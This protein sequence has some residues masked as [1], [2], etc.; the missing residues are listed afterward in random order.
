M[1][2]VVE[3]GSLVHRSKRRLQPEFGKLMHKQTAKTL[4]RERSECVS[5][6]AEFPKSGHRFWDK[7][8]LKQRNLS[9]HSLAKPEMAA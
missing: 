1:L 4:A 7:T 9:S 6:L 3:A 5:A 8:L 2:F